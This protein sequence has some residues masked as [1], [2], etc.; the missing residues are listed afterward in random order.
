MCVS[1]LGE[2]GQPL[3]PRKHAFGQEK[4]WCNHRNFLKMKIWP[5]VLSFSSFSGSCP[6]IELLNGSVLNGPCPCLSL[7][8]PGMPYLVTSRHQWVSQLLV[9]YCH[10]VNGGHRVAYQP[11]DAWDGI[12][13]P[14]CKCQSCQGRDTLLYAL[15]ATTSF[16]LCM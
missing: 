10:S 11:H 16:Q 9:F 3:W 13:D 14:V 8:Q 6:R 1:E 5:S 2:T 4:R 12:D 15:P 7:S